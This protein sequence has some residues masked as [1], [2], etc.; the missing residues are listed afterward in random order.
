M[1]GT[2]TSDPFKLTGTGK[3]AF[4]MGAAKNLDKIYIEFFE[5]DNETALLKVTN[6]DY[7]EP[8]ITDQMIRKIVD[9]SA[10]LNKIIYIKV[11]DSDNT[12]DFGYVNLD[13]FVVCL[14]EAEVATFQAEREAQIEAYGEPE[15]EED[16]TSTTIING[17]FESGDLT[18]WKQLSGTAFVG[19]YCADDSILLDG[20]F[21]LW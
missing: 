19:S 17:G 2:L 5:K 10:H 7:N 14:T 3:I 6:T 21:S 16:P 11:T 4:K 18:G 9:L 20:P 8:F 15:F 1:V 13:D 12:D